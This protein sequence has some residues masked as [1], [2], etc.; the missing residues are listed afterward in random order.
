MCALHLSVAG[1]GELDQKSRDHLYESRR[2]GEHAQ[3]LL[4]QAGE[5]QGQAF[6]LRRLSHISRRLGEI[7]GAITQME[8]SLRILREIGDQ[9]NV[10]L[11]LS[12]VGEYYLERNDVES[13]RKAWS[14]GL[15]LAERIDASFLG[16]LQAQLKQL[17]LV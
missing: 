1:E 16:N 8:K 2:H 4:I 7:D 17:E 9:H 14:E 10:A 3:K 5:R 6:S 11:C 12:E 13:A 15:S